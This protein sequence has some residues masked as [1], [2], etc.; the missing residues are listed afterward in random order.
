MVAKLT[1]SSIGSVLKEKRESKNQGIREAAKEIG[2]SS[3]TLSRI[4]N[5]KLPDLESFSKI[6]KWLHINPAELLDCKA[7]DSSNPAPENQF[8]S[9][10]LRADKN[11]SNELTKALGEMIFA[12]QA[13]IVE[14]AKDI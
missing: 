11:M 8:V 10:H 14:E 2:I 9:V 7:I 6:C 12:T 3:A 4:E 5:G 13:M 1:L